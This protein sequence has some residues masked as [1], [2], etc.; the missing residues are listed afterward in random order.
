[1]KKYPADFVKRVKE[2]Y[3]KSEDLHK[4]L[5]DGPGDR[6]DYIISRYLEESKGFRMSPSEIVKAFEEGREQEVLESAKEAK[7][8]FEL[9]VEWSTL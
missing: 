9:C 5:E 6:N 8:R 1:M 2:V 3:P 7:E 4:A